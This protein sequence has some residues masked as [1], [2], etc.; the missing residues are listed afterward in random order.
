M[1]LSI[2]NIAWPNI[3]DEAMYKIMKDLGFLGLEIAP[4]K[5]F[6]D[7]PYEKKREAIL[8]KDQIQ[9]QFGFEISSIQSIWYGQS[10]RIFGTSEDRKKL[11]AYT[12]KAIDFAE[13]INCGNLVFGCPQNRIIPK[14]GDIQIAVRFFR[15]LG[16][17]AA[18]HHTIIAMEANPPIY[19]TNF[20]NTTPDT[21]SFVEAVNSNGFL[22]NLDIGT[23]IENSEEISILYGKEHLINHVHISEPG[24]KPIRE[25]LLHKELAGFLKEKKYQGFVSIEVG[26][27]ENIRE[28][29]K[30]MEY[31]KIL[32]G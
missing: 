9:D 7:K 6:S 4:T 12:Q 28:L 5:L 23:M 27:Q 10:E 15:E 2:S 26:Q 14:D 17:Y 24:L 31:V 3:F 22:L 11:I 16:D 32:F 25:R 20:L 19:H 1:K 21:I 18:A 30:M 8:W 29:Q 13:A